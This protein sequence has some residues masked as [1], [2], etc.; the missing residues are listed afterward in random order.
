MGPAMAPGADDEQEADRAEPANVRG[1]E[2]GAA[3]VMKVVARDGCDARSDASD[4][5]VT[6]AGTHGRLSCATDTAHR[7]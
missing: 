3:L 4:S 2:E 7:L 5:P 1:D 6:S